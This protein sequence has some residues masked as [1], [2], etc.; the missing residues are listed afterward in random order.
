MKS[1]RPIFRCVFTPVHK[2]GKRNADCKQPNIK[3]FFCFVWFFFFLLETTFLEFISS[4]RLPFNDHDSHCS[5]ISRQLFAYF[6]SYPSQFRF[7]IW[8]R[9]LIN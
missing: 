5:D 3:V 4:S 6:I 9:E 7:T 1:P 8:T 2:L